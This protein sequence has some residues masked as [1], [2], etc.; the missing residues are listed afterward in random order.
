MT[1][2]RDR[3]RSP[4]PPQS[5][6][7]PPPPPGRRRRRAERQ[8]PPRRRL[9][10]RA[11]PVRSPLAGTITW[12][13]IA[14]AIVTTWVVL[15]GLVASSLQHSHNQSVLYSKLREQLALETAPLGGQ[16]SPGSP[17]AVMD[18]PSAGLRSEVIVEGTAPRDLMNGPGHRRDTVL[19][20]QPGVSVVYG[21]AKLF[22]GPFHRVT[23]AHAGDVI[24]V[25]TGEGTAKYVVERIRHAGDPFSPALATGAGR[26]TLVTSESGGWRG[27]WAPSRAVYVDAALQGKAFV[28]PGGR[29]SYVPTAETAMHG[30]VGALYVLVLWLPV[31]VIGAVVAV[32]A[33][34]RWGRWQTWLVGMP[35][36]LAG[37]WGVSQT[38]VQ[39]L[40]NLM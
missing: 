11:A 25:T 14:L 35:I 19:P 7:P 39:L 31:L 24:T 37:L 3:V 26:L 40:P 34:D 22:G 21:R 16:V 12:A 27:G 30:D 32:W 9:L 38:A 15:Y 20:G 6:T 2:V 8:R 4:E 36:I 1:M 17:I 29:P 23:A 10:P 5:S 13:L 18:M 28:D 33:Y